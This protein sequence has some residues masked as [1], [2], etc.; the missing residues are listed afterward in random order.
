M[1]CFPKRWGRGRQGTSTSDIHAA[2]RERLAKLDESSKGWTAHDLAPLIVDEC[3]KALFGRSK[4]L[5]GRPDLIAIFRAATSELVRIPT[6][7][8]SLNAWP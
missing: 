5:D 8:S 2:I 7:Q 1:T 6:L 4:T 3:S